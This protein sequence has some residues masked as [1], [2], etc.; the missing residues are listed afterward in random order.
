VDVN[1]VG[2]R[3]SDGLDGQVGLLRL[4]PLEVVGA[5][6]R[7]A[8]FNVLSSWARGPFVFLFHDDMA[9]S[10]PGGFWVRGASR[11]VISVVSRTGRA[12]SGFRLR[13][14]SDIA[15]TVRVDTADQ[16]LT[17]HLAAGQPQEIELTPN[18]RDGALR[19]VLTPATG[20]RPSDRD[21]ASGDR[22]FLGCWVEIA[23]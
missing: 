4:R 1:F 23:P 6:H 21:P 17:L 8:A 12:E 13:L 3:A 16:H 7:V 2:F 9:Y 14:R 10:E 5:L 19:I 18:A 15:N 20:F 11:V 22:R